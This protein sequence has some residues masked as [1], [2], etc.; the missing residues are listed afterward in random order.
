M[1]RILCCILLICTLLLCAGCNVQVSAPV[2]DPDKLLIVTT[3]FPPYDFAR[4]IVGDQAEVVMLLAPGEESHSFEP[5]PKDIMTLTE[6]DLF[7]F[8]GG[9]SDAWAKK[10]MD[11]TEL[12]TSK[13]FMM[14]DCVDTVSQDAEGTVPHEA[15]DHSTH[16]AY[17]EHVWTSPRNATVICT[18][19]S[20]RL[21]EID[22]ANAET[23]RK[24]FAVYL[25]ELALLDAEFTLITAGA[26]RKTVVFADR[27]PF[28]YLADT[29]GLTYY[30]AFPGCSSETEPDAATMSFLIDKVNSE[31]IPAVFYTEHSNRKIADAVS[32]ATGA[33]QLLMHSCHTLTNEEAE[34]GETYISIM[35]QNAAALKEALS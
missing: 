19:L 27:F 5:T 26:D 14:M 18:K 35:K 8:G 6:A 16:Y 32:E 28:R 17:D 22:P 20:E 1:K 34:R 23:Y 29:Y 10:L 7:I 24:N 15:H 4:Q 9:E 12:D 3:N 25:N 30:A 2:H 13:S 33:K 31:H 21:A 11:S